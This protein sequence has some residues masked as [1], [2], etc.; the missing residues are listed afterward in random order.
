VGIGLGFIILI[1]YYYREILDY[2]DDQYDTGE[3]DTVMYYVYVSLLSFLNGMILV[4]MDEIYKVLSLLVVN[5]ENHKYESSRENSFILKNY[6]FQ[7]VNSYITL[8]YYSF[9]QRDFDLVASSMA[10]TMIGK[11]VLN[12]GI[13]SGLPWLKWKINYHFFWKKYKVYRDERLKELV[14]SLNN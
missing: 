14:I 2:V 3:L 10:T 12:V 11:Q 1:F 6:L 7:F 5:W 9:S 4:L 8:F 13:S